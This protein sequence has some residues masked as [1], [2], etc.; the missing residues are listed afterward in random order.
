[1]KGLLSRAHQTLKDF[2]DPKL[3]KAE[4]AIPRALL[5]NAQGIVIFTIVKAG[6]VVG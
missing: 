4:E 1:M 5:E 3:I 2:I 6:L